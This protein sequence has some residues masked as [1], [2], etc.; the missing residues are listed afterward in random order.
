MEDSG[1]S[2]TEDVLAAMTASL[3]NPD[4]QETTGL[5]NIHRRL[6]L[7][8]GPGYGLTFTRSPLGGLRVTM[9][10]PLDRQEAAHAKSPD[11]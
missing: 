5:I 10:I 9:R 8:F 6:R 7:R 1:D 11:C 3:T 2:L 4:A